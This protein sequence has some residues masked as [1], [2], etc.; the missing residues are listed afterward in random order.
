LPTSS[1]AAPAIDPATGPASPKI[2]S[3]ADTETKKSY[4][5][6]ALEIPVF[7]TALSLYDRAVYDK[8]VYGSTFR[9]TSDHLSPSS[10]E[11]DEDPF[12]V[13]QFSHPY[14]GATMHGL[15]RSAGLTFW[16]SL[17]Y[18]NVGSFVW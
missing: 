1:R 12:N 17:F 7:L 10:W 18:S 16:E 6:P 15:G 4:V 5:I 11:Y 13:N 2:T 8:A 9:T 3:T 14:L